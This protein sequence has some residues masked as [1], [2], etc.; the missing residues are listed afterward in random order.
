MTGVE[1]SAFVCLHCDFCK[2]F[3]CSHDGEPCSYCLYETAFDMYV[4]GLDML[5]TGDNPLI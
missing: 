3:G 2:S 1:L 5:E 4:L